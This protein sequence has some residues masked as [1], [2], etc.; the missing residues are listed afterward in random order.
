[1]L[2]VNWASTTAQLLHSRRSVSCS[3]GIYGAVYIFTDVV[4]VLQRERAAVRAK[5]RL[6]AA[7]G[8]QNGRR[9]VQRVERAGVGQHRRPRDRADHNDNLLARAERRVESHVG[10]R[11]GVRGEQ[12]AFGSGFYGQAI[13]RVPLRVDKI[14][15]AAA[16]TRSTNATPPVSLRASVNTFAPVPPSS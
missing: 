2:L 8:V 9:R 7:V 13:D 14:A 4:E 11:T 1:M 15:V 5:V 3:L 16:G 6:Q 12:F 10:N